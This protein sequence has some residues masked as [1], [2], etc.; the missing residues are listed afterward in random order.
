MGSR[1]TTEIVRIPDTALPPGLYALAV[2]KTT[3]PYEDLRRPTLTK[4]PRHTA[5][6]LTFRVE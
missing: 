4:D 2:T 3:V 1:M 5:H 6:H